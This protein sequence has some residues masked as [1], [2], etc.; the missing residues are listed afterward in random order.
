MLLWLLTK[1]TINLELAG[2]GFWEL[3]ASFLLS[4]PL[5]ERKHTAL[6]VCNL[7]LSLGQGW[8]SGCRCCGEL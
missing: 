6:L 2:K 7:Q 1:A 5:L 8:G 3:V 4:V